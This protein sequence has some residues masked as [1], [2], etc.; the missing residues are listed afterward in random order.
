MSYCWFCFLL[1]CGWLVHRCT[2]QPAYSVA[3]SERGCKPLTSGN[4]LLSRV[5]AASMC[6]SSISNLPMVRPWDGIQGFDDGW[7]DETEHLLDHIPNNTNPFKLCKLCNLLLLLCHSGAGWPV[8][9]NKPL[10]HIPHFNIPTQSYKIKILSD[11]NLIKIKILN[12][13]NH[14]HNLIHIKI[15]I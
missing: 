8:Q 3:T 2:I 14:N 13:Q 6:S 9:P 4:C 7:T 11:L 5:W 12:T 10:H 1:H 15:I